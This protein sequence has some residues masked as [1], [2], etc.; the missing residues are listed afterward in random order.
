MNIRGTLSTYYNHYFGGEMETIKV[1][2]TPLIPYEWSYIVDE[3]V[4][5]INKDL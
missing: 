4:N 2:Q 3:E 1:Y 5:E